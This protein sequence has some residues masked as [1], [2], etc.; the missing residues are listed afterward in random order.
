MHHG[1]IGSTR[2]P[3]ILNDPRWTPAQPDSSHLDVF[4]TFPK[5]GV[6]QPTGLKWIKSV[7]NDMDGPLRASPRSAGENPVQTIGIL[8]ERG[9]WS[10]LAVPGP[11]PGASSCAEDK[12]TTV[13]GFRIEKHTTASDPCTHQHEIQENQSSSGIS[14]QFANPTSCCVILRPSDPKLQYS[15]HSMVP[16]MDDPA[17]SPLR[18]TYSFY[19][20]PCPFQAI[21]R[22]RV[23]K[24]LLHPDRPV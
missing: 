17:W 12:G 2:S 5:E 11:E 21:C 13:G 14:A 6:F 3:S 24:V 16:C 20:Q 1:C 15:T 22:L 8:L 10:F 4:Y 18:T 19:L 7:A 9:F 23:P